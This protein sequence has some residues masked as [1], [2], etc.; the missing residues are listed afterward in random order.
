MTVPGKNCTRKNFWFRDY[1]F[2]IRFETFWTDSNQKISS[3]NIFWLCNVFTNLDLLAEIQHSPS[4]KITR[5]IS[6]MQENSMSDHFDTI[7]NRFLVP[8]LVYSKKIRSIASI[9]VS[10]SFSSRGADHQECWRALSRIILKP[11]PIDFSSQN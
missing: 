7:S 4:K 1:R 11:F 5:E 10:D 9:S 8:K 2:K 6:K 3:T